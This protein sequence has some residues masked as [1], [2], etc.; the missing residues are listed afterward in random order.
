MNST[1]HPPG[2][3]YHPPNQPT[4]QV[5]VLYFNDSVPL[6]AVVDVGSSMEAAG[7]L[8]AWKALPP[9]ATSRLPLAVPSAEAVNA[10][11]QAAHIEVLA[12]RQVGL[13]VEQQLCVLGRRHALRKAARG[14]RLE[15][16]Q[17]WL[18][19]VG[20]PGVGAAESATIRD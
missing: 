13:C 14:W 3:P 6:S 20:C 8:A 18:D 15:A 1:H 19:D 12:H 2:P 5:G 11:L 7:F 9:E 10:R 4:A 16:A 17:L